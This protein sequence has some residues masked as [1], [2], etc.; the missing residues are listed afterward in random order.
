MLLWH[1]VFFLIRLY[2][3]IFKLKLCITIPPVNNVVY[4]SL[5]E[6]VYNVE[7]KYF[8]Y[9]QHEKDILEL[10]WDRRRIYAKLYGLFAVSLLDYFP[11]IITR[12]A[13]FM[14]ARRRL[15]QD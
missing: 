13:D 6:R 1:L 3:Q 15:F 4:M 8:I 12:V 7:N 9:L 11:V 14:Q 5:V 2:C 10:W